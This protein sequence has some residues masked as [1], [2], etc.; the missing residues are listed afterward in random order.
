MNEGVELT[1]GLF[2]FL[3]GLNF[4]ATMIASIVVCLGFQDELQR[5]RALG[6][7]TILVARE[8]KTITTN[9]VHQVFVPCHHDRFDRGVPC[10]WNV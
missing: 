10:V 3:C 7:K 5:S 9:V 8:T 6:S 1:L 4:R 2:Y